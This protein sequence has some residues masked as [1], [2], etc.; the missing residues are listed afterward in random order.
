MSVKEQGFQDEEVHT[1][2]FVARV[3]ETE[4]NIKNSWK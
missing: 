1:N 2:Y 4:E 3:S